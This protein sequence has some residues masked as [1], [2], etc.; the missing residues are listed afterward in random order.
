MIRLKLVC[1]TA[2]TKTE[3]APRVPDN[4]WKPRRGKYTP[5]E[6]LGMLVGLCEEYGRPISR[7]DVKMAC[8]DGVLP[9]EDSLRRYFGAV[10]IAVIRA[11]K[12]FK[13]K[14]L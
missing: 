9:N 2:R 7:D 3:D 6:L 10:D 8:H 5:E 12:I 13:A 1:K 14:Q 4:S 11:N